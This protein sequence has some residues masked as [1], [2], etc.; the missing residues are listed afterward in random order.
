MVTSFAFSADGAVLA[1]SSEET[2]SQ[3][4][5]WNTSNP[6]IPQKIKTLN[7]HSL[8]VLDLLFDPGNNILISGSRD[9]AIM[10]WDVFSPK[11]VLDMN[12]IEVPANNIAF[13]P[14][15]N[16]LALNNY[17]DKLEIWNTAYFTSPKYIK[18]LDNPVSIAEFNRSGSLMAT[19][20]GNSVTL[21]DVKNFAALAT[22]EAGDA[23]VKA[24]KFNA[25]GSL[26]AVM[27]DDIAFWDVTNPQAPSQITRLPQEISDAPDLILNSDSSFIAFNAYGNLMASIADKDADKNII[28]WDVTNRAAPVKLAVL[29]GHTRTV[30]S[31]AFSPINNNFLVSASADKTIILWDVSDSKSPVKINIISEHSDWVNSIAFNIEGTLLASG[32]DDKKVNIWNISNPQFPTFVSK[33]TGHVDSIK[34]VTFS[35]SGNYLASLSADG[36]IIFW[37]INPEAWMQKACAI[38]GG[39]LTDIQ[40]RQ[41]FPT[42]EYRPTCSEFIEQASIAPPPEGEESSSTIPIC[43]D[44]PSCNA[45]A[46]KGLDLF[47][48]DDV[49]YGLYKLSPNTSYQILTPEFTCI[50]ERDNSTGEPRISCTGPVNTEFELMLCNTNCPTTGLVPS[51]KCEAGFGLLPSGECCA[52]LSTANN[53]CKTETLILASCE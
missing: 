17:E 42:E 45:P 34:N 18:T 40:W 19:A 1:S 9:S 4:V 22:F 8:S 26:L 50:K 27:S 48:V 15:G 46:C 41:L 39:D 5:L 12:A 25:D 35:P 20:A 21:W 2:K 28:L 14:K 37:D 33:M 43:G 11:L 23:N 51:S 13:A 31:I 32:S 47:C 10:L 29:D 36:E 52:P 44:I 16:L 49:A 3:I 38:T 30:K 6:N 7:G 24:L 53:G